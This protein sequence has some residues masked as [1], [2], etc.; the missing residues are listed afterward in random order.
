M[1]ASIIVKVALG[2]SLLSAIFSFAIAHY[3][4]IDSATTD[5]DL[6]KSGVGSAF[7]MALLNG[8]VSLLVTGGLAYVAFFAD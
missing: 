6:Y 2:L 3:T 1:I 8:F 4:N 5:V 7:S